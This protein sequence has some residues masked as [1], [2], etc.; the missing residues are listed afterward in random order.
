M[1]GYTVAS[2][3]GDSRAEF[4]MAFGSGFFDSQ[5]CFRNRLAAGAGRVH[6]ANGS[7]YAI[8]FA[9]ASGGEEPPAAI[10]IA[11]SSSGL[12]LRAESL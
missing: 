5:D 2:C 8:A 6:A 1:M 12:R 4:A 7:A 3:P 9:C 11:K 10:F